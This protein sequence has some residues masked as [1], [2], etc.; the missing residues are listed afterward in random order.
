MSVRFWVRWVLP[1]L[2]LHHEHHC[3]IVVNALCWLSLWQVDIKLL[4]W[5]GRTNLTI[6]LTVDGVGAELAAEFSKRI[7][8]LDGAMGTMLQRRRL[9]EEDFRGMNS[10]GI[11]VM[12]TS[13]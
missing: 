4:M 8:V 7:M 11:I 3:S 10:C 12:R 5:P 9:E 2:L 13:Y 6:N 1:Q